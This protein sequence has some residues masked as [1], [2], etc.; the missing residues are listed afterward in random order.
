MSVCLCHDIIYNNVE[1]RVRMQRNSCLQ[2]ITKG[3]TLITMAKS[4]QSY[5]DLYVDLPYSY[6][7]IQTNHIEFYCH[8][9]FSQNYL[10]KTVKF[11]QLYVYFK[12]LF[13]GN[14]KR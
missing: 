10:H 6:L 12:L 4:E 3:L 13:E 1:S 2:I 7:K 14:N 9:Y 11:I 8:L 5:S